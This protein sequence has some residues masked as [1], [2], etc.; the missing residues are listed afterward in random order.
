MLRP[1]PADPPFGL[2]THDKMSVLRICMR[3]Q[4]DF[5]FV[6]QTAGSK[7]FNSVQSQALVVG[8]EVGW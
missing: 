4:A 1:Q 5:N 3:H 7:A 2:S 6:T 8:F